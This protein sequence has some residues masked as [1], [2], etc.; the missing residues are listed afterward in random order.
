MEMVWKKIL[1]A[2]SHCRNCSTPISPIHL[3]PI[4]GGWIAKGKCETCR[5]P[6]PLLFPLVEL[7]FCLQFLVNLYLL[8]NLGFAISF[9][10]FLGH[11]LVSMMTDAGKFILDYENIPFLLFFG[12]LC[13]YFSRGTLPDTMS[14]L[15]GLGFLVSFYLL[16]FLYPRGMGLGDVFLITAYSFLASH[17]WWMFFLNASYFLALLGSFVFRKKG[18]KFL[19]Q[20]IPMGFYLGVGIGITLLLK[21]HLLVDFN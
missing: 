12:I 11:V 16:F 20:K 14:L 6:F 21:A 7:F 19:K 17:P 9:S 15:V 2:P 1:T 10:F 5:A 18:E 3:L 13:N 8:K 4:L